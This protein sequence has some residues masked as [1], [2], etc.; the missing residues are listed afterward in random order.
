M[1][2]RAVSNKVKEGALW[3]RP[4]PHCRPQNM[5]LGQ[6][7]PVESP[8]MSDGFPGEQRVSGPP[9]FSLT[10]NAKLITVV[11]ILVFNGPSCLTTQPRTLFFHSPP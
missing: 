6:P 9:I 3:Q 10:L 11:D 8:G 5:L 2:P 1:W 7:W 4:P